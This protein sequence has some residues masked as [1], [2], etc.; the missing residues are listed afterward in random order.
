MTVSLSLSFSSREKNLTVGHTSLPV[1]RTQKVS[2][3]GHL[4]QFPEKM[5]GEKRLLRFSNIF[6]SRQDQCQEQGGIFLKSI[7]FFLI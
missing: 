3:S 4:T 5:T 7:D 1:F 2:F 6:F